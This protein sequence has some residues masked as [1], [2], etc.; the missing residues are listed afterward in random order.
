MWANGFSKRSLETFVTD[1]LKARQWIEKRVAGQIAV[2]DEECREFY[3]TNRDAFFLALRLRANH[4]FLAA[5]P[6]TP[7]EMIESKRFLIETLSQRLAKGEDFSSLVTE[8]S[9]DEATRWRG[10]DLGFF[11]SSRMLPEFF[12]AATTLRVGEVSKPVRS[13]LGFHII[14]LTAIEPARVLPFEE[15]RAEI[16]SVLQSNHRLLLTDQL[17]VQLTRDAEYF[18]AAR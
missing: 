12:A 7:P 1:N 17:T 13:R 9:E 11:A 15:V 18:G 14:Q 10:G 3:R 2:T 4:L 5:P 16:I 8:A 6:E